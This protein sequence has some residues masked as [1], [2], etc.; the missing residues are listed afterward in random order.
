MKIKKYIKTK[1]GI[2]RYLELRK[3]Y[4]KNTFSKIRLILYVIV[5]SLRDIFKKS[6]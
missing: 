1:C 6:S 5:A 4:N 2:E 3:D